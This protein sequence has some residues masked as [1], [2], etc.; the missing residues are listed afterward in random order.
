LGKADFFFDFGDEG[1]LCV[2]KGHGR[3][4]INRFIIIFIWHTNTTYFTRQEKQINSDIITNY[5]C[6]CFT[7]T[8]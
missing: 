6:P 3:T 4:P 1:S 7:L 5:P 2:I 8:R